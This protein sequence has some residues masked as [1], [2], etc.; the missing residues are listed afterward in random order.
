MK[1]ADTPAMPVR[2]ADGRPMTL[3]NQD[4]ADYIRDL[5]PAIGLTKREHFAA[6]A[7]QACMARGGYRSWQALSADSVEI[8]DALLAELE[9]TS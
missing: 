1:N 5:Q 2:R 6:M 7:L 8:A 3:C 9:R 4:D